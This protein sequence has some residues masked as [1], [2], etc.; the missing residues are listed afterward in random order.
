LLAHQAA[1]LI[2]GEPV[3]QGHRVQRSVA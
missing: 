3:F 1:N 2:Q